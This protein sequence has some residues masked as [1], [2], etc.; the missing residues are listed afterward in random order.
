MRIAFHSRLRAGIRNKRILPAG[1]SGAL[2]AEMTTKQRALKMLDRRDY[3]RAELQKK[4]VEKGEPPEA[5]AEA[6]ERLAELGF[7][8]DARY[9]ALV[10]RQYAGKGYGAKRVRMELQRRGVP[11]ELW[12][13]A[14]TQMPDQSDRLDCLLRQKL[15]GDFDRASIKK[16]TD[17]LARRG[18][19]WDAISAALERLRNE[20]LE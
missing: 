10:V 9:A 8:D 5:A 3:A 19:A 4:L 15:G 18:Y 6:V 1:E 17:A 16:A 14:L 11:R 12:D 2:M 7:V 13:E 20:E